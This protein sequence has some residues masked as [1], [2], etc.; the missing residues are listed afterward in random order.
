HPSTFLGNGMTL[1]PP[2][3][4]KLTATAV[5]SS[6]I[7]LSWTA[8][9]CATS[10]TI[11]RETS[12]TGPFTIIQT[13][14][15]GTTFSSTGLSASTTYF[16]FVDAVNSAGGSLNSNQASATTQAGSGSD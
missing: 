8:R 4:T 15:T 13:G 16:Y 5:S 7:N 3:P 10:Y 14:V 6:Q 1:R 12:A 11:K 2:A 9:S